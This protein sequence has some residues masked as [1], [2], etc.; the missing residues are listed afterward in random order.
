MHAKAALIVTDTK[1]TTSSQR[2]LWFAAPFV[3]LVL[4]L[5]LA[6][7]TWQV[8]RLYWKEALMADIEQRIHAA[9][10]PLSD[11][12]TLAASGGDIEYRTV[13]L[14]GTFEHTKEQHFFATFQGQSGYYI[15][16]PLRLSDDRTIFV[17]RGFVLYDMKEPAKRTAGEVSGV[18][19][20][21]GLARARLAAKPSS[22]LPDN[23]RAKN[24]YYW[25][26]LTA[27]TDS[28]GIE[29]GKVLPFFVDANDAPNPGGWPKG[30]V[31]L[32]DLPNNHLQ[33]AITWYGLAL[34]LVIVAGFAYVRGVRNSRE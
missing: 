7:G 34:A 19:S 18:V 6:L 27:M 21:E 31:T 28:A 10:V 32:I 3:L 16:T 17:N 1:T 14:S 29:P 20:I 9:P 2:S 22:L 26:D 13:A 12:E 8:K 5:L 24:I 11:I 23:D 25:K 30:G 33:Y 15:Y 4:V